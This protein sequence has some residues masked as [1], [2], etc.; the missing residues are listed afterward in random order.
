MEKANFKTHTNELILLLVPDAAEKGVV[1]LKAPQGDIVSKTEFNL[2]VLPGITSMTESARPGSNITINGSFLNWVKSITFTDDKSVETFVSQS[3][4]QLVVTVPADAKTGPLTIYYSGTD[5]ADIETTQVLEVILP[6]A[7][8]FA[9]NPLKHGE[10]LTITGTD[11]DLVRKVYFTQGTAAVETF[12][13]QTAT[14]LVV[15]VPAGTRLGPVTLEAASGE[16]TVSAT[17]VDVILPRITGLAPNPIKHAQNVTI[18]GTNLDLVDKIFFNGHATAITSFVSQT[19]TQIVVTVPAGTTKGPITLE[20]DYNERTVS[21]LELDL[22]LPNVTNMT[23]NPA[24]PGGVVTLTGTNLDL[25]TSVTF[26]NAAPVTTFESHTATQIEVTVP[27]GVLRGPLSLGVVNSTVS[28]ITTGI[29][30]YTGAAPPP[31]V[32]FLFYDDEVTSNWNGW[33]GGGWGGTHDY[34]NSAPVRTGSKS[35]KVDYVGG[36]GAPLQLGGANV[37]TAGYT[38]FKVSIFGAPGSGGKKVNIGINGDDGATTLDIVEG[39]WTDYAIPLASIHSATIWT[40][41]I[42]KEFSGTGGFTIYVDAM[43]LD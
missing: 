40:Q 34:N 42:L 7:T 10:N 19:A 27:T 31:T 18:T 13:S 22:V 17:S 35:V 28:V 43:G 20:T 14:Q 36:W 21:T 15:T 1:T 5:S 30:D 32:A 25:V 41:L 12:G 11:L 37:N 8:G 26:Q 6:V 29:L 38:H 16:K 23:P 33:V 4:N 3:F 2:N 9:P 24:D 39:E